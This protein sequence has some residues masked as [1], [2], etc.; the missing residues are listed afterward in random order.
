[1]AGAVEAGRLSRAIVAMRNEGMTL[2]PSL[3]ISTTSSSP[4]CVGAGM[5]P[6]SVSVGG[7]L[8]VDQGQRATEATAP[9]VMRHDVPRTGNRSPPVGPHRHCSS[10]DAEGRPSGWQRG[11]SLP[12]VETVSAPFSFV[13]ATLRCR[14]RA[15]PPTCRRRGLASLPLPRA[16]WRSLVVA[17]P[18][19]AR[20]RALDLLQALAPCSSIRIAWPPGHVEGGPSRRLQAATRPRGLRRDLVQEVR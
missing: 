17:D 19:S 12:R 1:M 11:C 14:R 18:L 8:P 5:A 9:K 13:T 20:R 16:R 2:Q 4:P 15:A 3:T 7:R 6:S 10:S